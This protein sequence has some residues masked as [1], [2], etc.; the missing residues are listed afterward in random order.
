MQGL[1]LTARSH[2]VLVCGC[3][4]AALATTVLAGCGSGPKL[5]HVSGRLTLDGQPIPAGYV[6]FEPDAAK[7]NDG[8]GGFAEVKDGRY[9]TRNR[10]KGV[11]GGP[12]HVRLAGFDGKP[13]FVGRAF[14]PFGDTIFADYTLAI[15][16]PREDTT[17]DFNVPAKARIKVIQ[18]PAKPF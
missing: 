13:R 10:G 9:D 15:D 1:S 2:R 17:R 12:H 8:T 4:L 5:Y 14:M 18:A 3:A 6:Y 11:I 16:L 7:G